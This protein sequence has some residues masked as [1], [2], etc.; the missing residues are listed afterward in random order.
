MGANIF[1][2]LDHRSDPNVLFVILDKVQQLAVLAKAN[3][4]VVPTANPM[5]KEDHQGMSSHGMS[6]QG[7]RSGRRSGRSLQSNDV[8]EVDFSEGVE[9]AMDAAGGL[10][11]FRRPA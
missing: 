9:D 8:V 11:S 3:V 7:N 2:Y 1:R 5:E 4:D 10:K 6:D